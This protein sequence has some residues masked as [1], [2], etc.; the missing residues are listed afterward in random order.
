[1]N[2][3]KS[4]SLFMSFNGNG[5]SDKAGHSHLPWQGCLLGKPALHEG[6]S[7]V[8]LILDSI[9]SSMI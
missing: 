6:K 9:S 7:G 3:T 2:Q 4:F 5:L 1:M 8:Q